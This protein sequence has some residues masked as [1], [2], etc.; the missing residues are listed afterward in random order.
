MIYNR[1]LVLILTSGHR[2]KPGTIIFTLNFDPPPIHA[3]THTH[4]HTLK[5]GGRLTFQISFLH[6]IRN[7]TRQIFFPSP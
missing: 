6:W 3:H 5:K 4:T 1:K 2:F 7:I